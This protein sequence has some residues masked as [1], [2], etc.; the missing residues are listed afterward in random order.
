MNQGGAQRTDADLEG[1]A[2]LQQGAGVEADQMIFRAHRHFRGREK[3]VVTGRLVKHH[4]K[5]VGPDSGIAPEPWQIP[6]QFR[7]QGDGRARLFPLPQQRDQIQRQIR[8]TTQA[9]LPRLAV[10]IAR[11]HHLC[12]HIDT[13]GHQVTNRVGVVGTDVMAL[14]G[15]IVEI[16]PGLEKELGDLDVLR[17]AIGGYVP[18]IGQLRDGA[19]KALH[20]RPQEPLLQR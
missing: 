11:R 17:Q 6:V 15:T 9:H 19:V 16:A 12:D 18:G 8:I 14:L 3:R 1:A 2:V 10:G 4:I 20:E 7:H 13:Q 5:T